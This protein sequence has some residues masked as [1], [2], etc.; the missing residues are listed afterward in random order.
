PPLLLWD[1]A[2]EAG[3]RAA[4]ST[5]AFSLSLS[6]SDKNESRARMTVVK[7]PMAI[8]VTR[9]KFSVLD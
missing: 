7:E 3:V 2:T 9:L 5:K 4:A 1:H 6:S 8:I